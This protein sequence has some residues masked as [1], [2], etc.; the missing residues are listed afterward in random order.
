M[1]VYEFAF[2]ALDTST[3]PKKGLSDL[4]APSRFARTRELIHRCRQIVAFCRWVY[5]HSITKVD[6]DGASEEVAL[7]GSANVEL[8][9]D[10][11]QNLEAGHA[12]YLD[13]EKMF[14]KLSSH[15]P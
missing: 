6:A 8:I 12:R 7:P 14:C 4:G 9:S 2:L 5:P 11:F 3:R 15:S 10:F 13:Q 1:G